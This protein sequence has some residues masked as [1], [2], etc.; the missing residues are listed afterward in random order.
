MF[1]FYCLMF[2]SLQSVSIHSVEHRAG[3]DLRMKEMGEF[4]DR[5]CPEY[6]RLDDV[7]VWNNAKY[8]V[9]TVP[10]TMCSCP[11]IWVIKYI[12]QMKNG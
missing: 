10:K 2:Y 3:C 5:Y 12:Q 1:N 11:N 6:G 7:V 8:F 9:V 4:G